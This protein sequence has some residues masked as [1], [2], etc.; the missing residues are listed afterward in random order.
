MLTNATITGWRR[1]T[2]A[3]SHG[4]PQREDASAELLGGAG[5]AC[6]AEPKTYRLSRDGRTIVSRMEVRAASDPGFAAGDLVTIG[7]TSYEIIE[8]A[9]CTHGTLGHARMLLA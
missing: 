4:R 6:L 1:R 9:P 8:I 5:I 2:A 3:D 7:A